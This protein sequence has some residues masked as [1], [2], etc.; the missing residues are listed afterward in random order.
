MTHTVKWSNNCGYV[1]DGIAS[2]N[3]GNCSVNVESGINVNAG[4]NSNYT[5]C[6]LDRGTTISVILMKFVK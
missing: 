6:I 4:I 2:I 5:I 1:A 3:N